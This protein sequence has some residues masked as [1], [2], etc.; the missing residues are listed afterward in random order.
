MATVNAIGLGNHLGLVTGGCNSV[1][2]M[3]FG[4]KANMALRR[5]ISSALAHLMENAAQFTPRGFNAMWVEFV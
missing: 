4:S 1:L 2:C 3:R 5:L